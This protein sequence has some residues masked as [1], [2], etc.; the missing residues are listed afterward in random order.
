M[1]TLVKRLARLC[2]DHK[3]QSLAFVV[4]LLPVLLGIGGFAVDAGNVYVNKTNAQRTA[5]S[6]ALAGAQTVLTNSTTGTNDAKTYATSN[7]DANATVTFS[8]TT[9]AHDTITVTSTKVVPTTF[10]G[11]LHITSGTV[12]ATAKAQAGPAGTAY[13]V[14]PWAV[15]DDSFSGYN[16]HVGLQ[17][18]NY[19]GSGGSYNYVSITPPG[20]QTYADAIVNG[21]NAEILLNTN[22]PTNIFDG[23]GLSNVTAN[24][25]Q[26]RINAR[27]LETY[28]TVTTGSPRIIFVPVINGNVP[29]APSPVQ[30]TGFRA[31]FLESI[32]QPNS[33][34]WGRFVQVDLPAGTIGGGSVTDKG[35][36]VIKITN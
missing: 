1:Y 31:F 33:N 13:G 20:G 18:A 17:P 2:G 35:V 32:D 10:L 19:N 24:A 9:R 27:P 26:A 30:F 16:Q 8:T 25:L 21:V 7:G 29:N 28:L 5:D 15:N 14:L 11:M 6:A 4:V 36:Q 3:G 12:T 23:S 34:V 22:Y